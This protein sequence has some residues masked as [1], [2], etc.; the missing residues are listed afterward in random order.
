MEKLE[1]FT[2]KPVDWAMQQVERYLHHLETLPDTH[3]TAQVARKVWERLKTVVKHYPVISVGGENQILFAWDYAE[4]HVEVEVFADGHAEAFYYN[5][6]TQELWDEDT[7]P[8]TPG[9]SK[10]L[11]YLQRC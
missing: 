6:A 11:H 7:D 10:L 2:A 9:A 3:A 4:H 8:E 5:T 1:E